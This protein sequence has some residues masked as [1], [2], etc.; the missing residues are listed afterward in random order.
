M[1]FTVQYILLEYALFEYTAILLEYALEYTATSRKQL[2]V[3][4]A[5]KLS[6]CR[7]RVRMNF[8]R[9]HLLPQK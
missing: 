1:I 6:D 9:A 2:S 7:E 4:A 5:Q 3:F 8:R